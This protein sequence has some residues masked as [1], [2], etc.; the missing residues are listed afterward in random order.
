MAKLTFIGHGSLKLVIAD[1]VIYIDPFYA[2]DYSQKADLILITHE[3]Y[4][5]TRTE[6]VTL[7]EGGKI[8]RASDFIEGRKYRSIKFGDIAITAVPAYNKNHASGCVG[9]ILEAENKRLYFAGD[10]SKT[11]YMS[12]IKVDYAF[13]PTDGIFNM[14]PEEATE[15]A[16]IIDAKFAVP[17][18]TERPEEKFNEDVIK[19]FTP[20]NRLIIRPGEEINL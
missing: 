7:N 5:H 18:H 11:D 20:P 9:Y 3:H 6:L 15:C 12:Q 10:T 1:T 19:K 14:G 4:D 13:L 17:I 8:M 16:K 2:G